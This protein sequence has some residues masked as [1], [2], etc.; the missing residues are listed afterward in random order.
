MCAECRA[1]RTVDADADVRLTL[2]LVIH[3]SLCI[4]PLHVPLLIMYLKYKAVTGLVW[5]VR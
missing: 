1:T 5:E 3:P 4:L 2:D